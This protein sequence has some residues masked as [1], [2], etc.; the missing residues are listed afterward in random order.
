VRRLVERGGIID[1]ETQWQL[2]P[3][4]PKKDGVVPLC[5]DVDPKYYVVTEEARPAVDTHA[6]DY[7][8][9]YDHVL[10][11]EYRTALRRDDTGELLA[12]IG[13]QV[14]WIVDFQGTMRVLVERSDLVLTDDPILP[15]LLHLPPPAK[16]PPSGS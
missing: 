14:R 6:P 3:A 8:K 7:V 13:W 2:D 4:T 16:R 15:R 10:V 9:L 5:P 1:T 12:T 11:S